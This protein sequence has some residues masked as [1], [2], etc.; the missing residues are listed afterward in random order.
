M[1]G[2]LYWLYYAVPVKTGTKTA[3]IGLAT[4]T[5]GMPDSWKD[6]GQVKNFIMGLNLDTSAHSTKKGQC[7]Q[8]VCCTKCGGTGTP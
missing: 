5:T 6:Q 1:H 7:Q 8:G 2:G 3:I 4:S